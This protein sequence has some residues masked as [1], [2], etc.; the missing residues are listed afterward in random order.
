MVPRSVP[1]QLSN[2]HPNLHRF[3]SQLGSILGGFWEPSWHQIAS[4]VDAQRYQKNDHLS[5]RSWEQLSWI[6]ASIWEPRWSLKPPSW[7]QDRAKTPQSWRQDTL[8]TSTWSQDGPKTL[9][10][11]LQGSIL[12]DLGFYF[13]CFFNDFSRILMINFVA[14]CIL[15]GIHFA[16]ILHTH[17]CLKLAPHTTV[18]HKGRGRR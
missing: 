3:W 7:S 9:P 16:S 14:F 12:K 10:R 4:K 2:Q 8:K 5:D 13:G 17:L 11:H 15:F 1:K 6:L 18:C